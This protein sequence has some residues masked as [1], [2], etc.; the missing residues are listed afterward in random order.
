MAHHQFVPRSRREALRAM[1]AGFG[2]TALA[3]ISGTSLVAAPD[4]PVNPWSVKQPHFPPKA[5]HVILVFLTGGLSAIDSFD[6]KPLL[7][8]YDGQPLPYA[9]PRT[10]FAT[11]NLM[12]SPFAF[13]RY[14]RNG[15]EVSE[16]FPKIGGV[17]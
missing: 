9:T 16:I 15:T 2:I 10:E 5:K 11:G 7:D 6:H 12:R 4:D 8:R 13:T 17:I 1:G 3:G 14:G